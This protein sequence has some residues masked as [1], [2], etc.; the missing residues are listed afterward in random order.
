MFSRKSSEVPS[1]KFGCFFAKVRMFPSRKS[2]RQIFQRSLSFEVVLKE[3]TGLYCCP[4]MPCSHTLM[5]SQRQEDLS[6]ALAGKSI[7]GYKL[8]LPDFPVFVRISCWDI[9]KSGDYSPQILL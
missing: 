2:R 6:I 8:N 5:R 7:E 9:G 1:R 4:A 3:R